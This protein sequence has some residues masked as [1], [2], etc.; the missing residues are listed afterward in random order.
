[1]LTVKTKLIILHGSTLKQMNMN[2][3]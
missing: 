1:M 2:Y 3:K